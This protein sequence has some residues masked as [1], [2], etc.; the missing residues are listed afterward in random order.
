MAFHDQRLGENLRRIRLNAHMTQR[1]LSEQIGYQTPEHW[2]RI[3]SGRRHIP[4]H[5]LDRFCELLNVSYE[6]VLHSAK[7]ARIRSGA[8]S[9]R[10]GSYAERFAAIIAD[11][12]PDVVEG[13]LSV[14]E[15]IAPLPGLR[16]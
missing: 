8:E 14:C 10:A 6:E 9:E 12:P 13:I 1:V 16:K 4:L 7:E 15:R 11:C 2:S 5:M 3:E